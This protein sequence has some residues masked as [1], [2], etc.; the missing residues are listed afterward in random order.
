MSKWEVN[1]IALFIDLLERVLAGDAE[2]GD[3]SAATVGTPSAN[4]AG[5][6]LLDAELVQNLQDLDVRHSAKPSKANKHQIFPRLLA[7]LRT[8]LR[9]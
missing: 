5:I 7:S 2:G 6:G 1:P 4:S 8:I 3:G 9:R